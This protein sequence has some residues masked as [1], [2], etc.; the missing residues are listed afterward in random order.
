MSKEQFREWNRQSSLSVG[1]KDGAGQ[2]QVFS[3]N[4]SELLAK[5]L[6]ILSQYSTALTNRQLYY[7]LVASAIIPNAQEIYKRVCTFL[8]DARYAGL[9]DWDAIED[10][11]RTPSKRPEWDNI[12][13]LV[14]SACSS[15]RLPRW[16]GQE[17]YVEL[18]C[19]KQAMEGILKPIADK[20]HIYFGV[21][22]GYSS[23]ST[24]Y[25]QA[26]RLKS[27]WQEIQNGSIT[28][29]TGQKRREIPIM[30]YSK[31]RKKLVVLYLG[32]HDPSGL[33]M[34]RDIEERIAE[35]IIGNETSYKRWLEDKLNGDSD[36]FAQIPLIVEQVALT[37]EQ[38]GQ[39]N[40]PPNPAKI[41]DPRAKDYIKNFGDK[42]W[43]LDALKPDV[44]VNL[45]EQAILKYLDVTRYN[46]VIKQEQKDI[47]KLVKM[48]KGV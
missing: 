34:V 15:Y 46:A 33:D 9:I 32:D 26:K 12:A 42:S 37:T 7:Q 19:E 36:A 1:Y 20:Y 38:V 31:P 8:T 30:E 28:E 21:N 17:Y 22:K 41:T 44:L 13:G 3:I 25:E 18:F 16:S 24:M 14:K 48:V 23:A 10:R 4:Q 45:T 2:R 27:Q 39:Y 47:K 5:I 40:P 35:F 6:V 29:T 11:G 43:E